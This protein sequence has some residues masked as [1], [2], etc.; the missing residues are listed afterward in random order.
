MKIVSICAMIV[1]VA[2]L[3][4]ATGGCN[5]VQGMGEDLQSLGQGM[6]KSAGN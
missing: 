1:A 2:I 3:S 5:T 4:L 6:E